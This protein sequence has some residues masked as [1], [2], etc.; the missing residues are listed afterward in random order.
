V[1]AEL[2]EPASDVFIC[3]VLGNVVYKQCTD[4]TAVV[5]RGDGAVALLS[6]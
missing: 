4:G 5:G 2:F 3:P 1:V 6:S